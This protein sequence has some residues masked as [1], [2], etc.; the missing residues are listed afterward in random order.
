MI[1][2]AQERVELAYLEKQ[3]KPIWG[4]HL[5]RRE[6]LG[7][8]QMQRWIDLGIITKVGDEGY[9]ITDLGRAELNRDGGAES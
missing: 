7:D 8:P 2:T 3:R 1:L 6:P 5:E 9:I 4:G